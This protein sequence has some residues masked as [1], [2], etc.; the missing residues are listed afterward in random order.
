MNT[1]A[2]SESFQGPDFAPAFLPLVSSDSE[3]Y[4]D[5][6]NML[7]DAEKYIDPIEAELT[8]NQAWI[9]QNNA[10]MAQ[11]KMHREVFH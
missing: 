9:K 4:L 11:I 2:Q 6:N 10:Q 7:L 3:P 8:F 1:L 5:V